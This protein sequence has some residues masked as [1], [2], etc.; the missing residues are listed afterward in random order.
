MEKI[1]E[2]LVSQFFKGFVGLTVFYAG[3]GWTKDAGVW[4]YLA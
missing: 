1:M 2:E 3:L 4:S